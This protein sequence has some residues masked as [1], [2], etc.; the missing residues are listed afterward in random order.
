MANEFVS[1]NTLTEF[2]DAFGVKIQHPELMT[3]RTSTGYHTMVNNYQKIISKTKLK[4]DA[5]VESVKKHLF[6]ESY[7]DQKTGLTNAL[8][9]VKKAD[10]TKLKK[11]EINSLIQYCDKLDETNFEK[12]LDKI[13]H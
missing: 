11:A 10:G 1:R 4:K 6:N 13:I 9:G 5:V 8:K 12:Y 3:N 7:T 2:S